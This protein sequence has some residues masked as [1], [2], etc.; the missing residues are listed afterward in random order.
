MSSRYF[1]RMAAALAAIASLTA[2]SPPVHAGGCGC[3]APGQTVY[4]VHQ[5]CGHHCR[6]HYAPPVG[7]I[8]PS[9]PMMAAPM[10]AAPAMMAAPVMAPA[11]MAAPVAPAAVS[12]ATPA[13]APAMT[14]APAQTVAM[15]QATLQLSLVQAPA[16]GL[17]SGL[18]PEQALKALAMLA[19]PAARSPS[20]PAAARSPSSSSCEER[21]ADLEQ[22]VS[23]LEKDTRGIVDVLKLMQEKNK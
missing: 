13:F 8:V 7:M 10:M 9:A 2:A 14:L 4:H 17:S 6:H 3:E 18:T 16:S 19:D 12:F 1:V 21:L 5:R 22:R 11:M 15:P 20:A 23:Q